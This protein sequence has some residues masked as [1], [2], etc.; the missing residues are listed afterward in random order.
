MCSSDLYRVDRI[1]F[2]EIIGTVTDAVYAR[3]HVRYD[4]FSN[5]TARLRIELAAVASMA[6]KAASTPGGTRPLGVE[7]DPTVG[8]Y[9]KD[10]FAL[11]LEQATLVP[12]SGL[13]DAVNSRSARPAQL[14]RL[15]LSY[16]F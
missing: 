2:H 12:L 3:P 14:W 6:V 4:V 1:L 5:N 16:A 10:G 9:A 7:I 13:D 8:Y 15:H 11:A